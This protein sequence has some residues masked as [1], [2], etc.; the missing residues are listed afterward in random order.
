MARRERGQDP[1]RNLSSNRP[2]QIDRAGTQF[3]CSP[4]HLPESDLPVL[5]VFETRL[6]FVLKVHDAFDRSVKGLMGTFQQ[7]AHKSGFAALAGSGHF[8]AAGRFEKGILVR[9]HHFAKMRCLSVFYSILNN[10]FLF[11]FEPFQFSSYG[12][13]YVIRERAG[14]ALSPKPST[15]NVAIVSNAI[16]YS[17]YLYGRI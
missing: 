16:I 14:E 6:T 7:L 1:Y 11:L 3:E 4:V 5:H 15:F 10:P 9:V 13:D 2:T 17:K 12:K 8:D